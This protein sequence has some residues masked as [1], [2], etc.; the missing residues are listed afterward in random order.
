MNRLNG[1]TALV[2]GAS[3][4]IGYE[5]VLALLSEGATVYAGARR[6]DRM[7]D[8]AEKGAK[9][10]AL[11]VTNDAEM[12][13]T[14]Q[15]ILSETGSIDI[16]VNNAGYGSYGAVEDVPIEEGRRQFEVNIFGL[17]RLVQLVLPGMRERQNGRIINVSSIAGKIYT[18]FGGWYH[19]TK[20]A[21]EGLS[22]CL[23][24]ETEPFGVYTVIVEPGGIKTEWGIIAAD[25]LKKTSSN[26]AYAAEATRS[27]DSMKKLYSGDGLTEP[28]AIAK[29]ILKAV[30]AKK[31][32][33][34]YAAGYMSG[35]ALA[36]RK[37]LTDRL[38]D[39]MVRFMT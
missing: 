26:G 37:I 1:K 5:T 8:L 18:P 30:T 38:F 28:A 33:T 34:R 16:L 15:G 12:T 19:A 31:P 35:P 11:D 23:R 4:G 14:I 9:T 32:K 7:A 39:K 27:A 24:L 2:T 10:I 6:V 3:S 21:L 22:D 29:V 13:K 25:N 20:H 17:A 36:L